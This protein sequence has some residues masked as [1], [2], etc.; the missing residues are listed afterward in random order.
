MASTSPETAL[1][2]SAAA[3]DELLLLRQEITA[4]RREMRRDRQLLEK[5]SKP[6]V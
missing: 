3:Q 5:H 2:D 4:L 6:S 1:D